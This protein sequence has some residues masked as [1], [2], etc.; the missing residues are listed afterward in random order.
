MLL[1]GVVR[2][3]RVLSQVGPSGSRDRETN[4]DVPNGEQDSSGRESLAQGPLTVHPEAGLST[5][6]PLVMSLFRLSLEPRLL[7]LKGG[8]NAYG[9]KL[10][11]APMLG[12]T[13]PIC[14]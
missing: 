8:N 9:N 12:H 5:R 6:P 13:C 14:H 3:N 11:R 4:K 1:D 10:Y 7:V 2:K